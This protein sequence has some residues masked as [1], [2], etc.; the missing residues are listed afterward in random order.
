MQNW[1]NYTGFVSG[2]LQNQGSGNID[3]NLG[4]SITPSMIRAVTLHKNVDIEL[5]SYRR[6]PDTGLTNDYN[7]FFNINSLL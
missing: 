4:G 2:T 3:I 5:R 6:G 7:I 1:P